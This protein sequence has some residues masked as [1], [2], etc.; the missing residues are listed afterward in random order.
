MTNL[1][2]HSIRS[3]LLLLYVAEA[4][5]CFA[6]VYLL[7]AWGI[8]GAAAEGW[9]AVAFAALLALCAGAVSGA[10]GLYQPEAWSRANRLLLG[11]AVAGLLLLLLGGLR[12]GPLLLGL[13]GA[14][15]RLAA[16]LRLA[17]ERHLELR[18]RLPNRRQLVLGAERSER[19]STVDGQLDL[20]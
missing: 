20:R 11:T 16:P 4:L 19:H 10:S 3:E 2:G 1:F 9:G 17:R 18:Q 15:R 7:L 8:R 6:A 5:A 14:G 12:P 13:L